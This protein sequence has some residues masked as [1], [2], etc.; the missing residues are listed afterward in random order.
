MSTCIRWFTGYYSFPFPLKSVALIGGLGLS[1]SLLREVR[2]PIRPP[3]TLV[4]FNELPSGRVSS[5][6]SNFPDPPPLPPFTRYTLFT[7]TRYPSSTSI[8][9]RSLLRFA[10]P[11]YHCIFEGHIFGNSYLPILIEHL[12]LKYTTSSTRTWRSADSHSFQS[13]PISLD[14]PNPPSSSLSFFSN[15]ALLPPK[16]LSHLV[17]SA[18]PF[19][20]Q[21]AATW[22]PR[23]DAISPACPS[24]PR[25]ISIMLILGHIPLPRPNSR[26]SSAST[27]PAVKPQ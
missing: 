16:P 7:T 20:W 25:N 27:V 15:D 23:R 4:T 22:L 26:T 6:P 10:I 2:C 9:V 5:L 12:Q 24:P 14:L 21:P 18:D 3:P 19:N 8:Y 13:T 11:T 1:F 17:D